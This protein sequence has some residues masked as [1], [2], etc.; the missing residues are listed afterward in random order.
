MQKPFI[1]IPVLNRLDLLERCLGSVDL[2]SEV[3]VINNNAVDAAFRSGLHQLGARFSAVVFDQERNLGVSASWNLLART[4]F[5]RGCDWLF[6]GSNDTVLRPDSLAKTAAMAGREPEVGVW[7][8]HAWN[9]FLI[10]RTTIERVGQF[11][12]NF[13]PAYKEDQDYSYRCIL[14]GVERADV[15]GAGADHVGS[16]TVNSNECYRILSTAAGC[17]NYWYYLIKWG[18][19]ATKERFRKPFDAPDKDHSW[20][21][22]PGGIEVRDWDRV[23]GLAPAA[24]HSPGRP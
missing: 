10:R 18:G 12:E 20:W 17:W 15:P 11:D 13:Y 1:G 4:A 9:F 2:A 3:V 5:D 19:D 16:A 21:P 23:G 24:P 22:A 8:I 7:H 6:I 14:A